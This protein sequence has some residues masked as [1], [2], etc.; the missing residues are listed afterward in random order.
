LSER[1]VAV[2]GI[3]YR[4]IHPFRY[5]DHAIFFARD[6]ETRRLASLVAVYRGVLLYG[7]SGSGKSSL[8]NAGLIPEAIRL[9]FA[10]E[11]LRVQPRASEE[12]VVERI[13]SA[14]DEEELLPSVLALGEESPAR[15]VLAIDAFEERVRAACG[16]HRPLLI[17]D[18]FEEIV[19]LFD[20]VGARD[21]QRRLAE[22]LVRLLRGPLPVKVLLSFREDYLGKVKELLSA[23]PELVDQALRIAPPT[24]DAL[25][26]IIRGPFERYPDHFER[27]LSPALADRLVRVLAE[28]FGAG[29]IS[30]SEV[31]TVCLRLWQSDNPG[32]LLAQKGPQG[33]LED[34]LGEA[35]DAMPAHLRP[36]AVA[37]LGQM[38]TPAGTRNVI[39]AADLF[40]RVQEAERGITPGLLDQAL[41][42]LSQSRLVRRERRRDLNLYEITSE[43]LVPWI[44]RRRDEFRQLQERRRRRR[45]RRRLLIVTSLALALLL[46]A[47]VVT[48]LALLAVHS[49]DQAR[50]EAETA[51]KEAR[52]ATIFAL[53]SAAQTNAEKGPD[54]ALLLSLAAL[55]PNRGG[56]AI[57]AVARSNMIQALETTQ[58]KGVAGI[59][60][61]DTGPVNSVAFS[62][63]GRTLAS[64]SADGSARLWDLATHKQ[65]GPALDADTLPVSSVAFSPDGPTLAVGSDNDTVFLWDLATHTL[66]RSPLR[67]SAYTSVAF[68]LDGRTL[69]TGRDNGRVRLWDL[70]TNRPLGP[71]LPGR[72]SASVDSVAFSPDG[73]MLAAGS[74]DGRVRLW[75][76]ATNRPL[77]PPL[78]GRFSASVDSVAFSPDG[79]MLAAGSGDGRVR[80]WDPAAHRPLGPALT[81]S[82]ASVNSVAFSH[83]GRT[84]A[85]GSGDGTVELWDPATHSPLGPAL[86]ASAAS[87][88]SVAFSPD[89]RTLASGS[90]D[91]TVELWDVATAEQRGSPL[92]VITNSHVSSLALSPD[93]RTLALGTDLGTDLS[94]VQLWDVATH[95][96]LGLP[97]T[98]N[99][100]PVT[101]PVSS[102]ALSP[103]GRTLALGTDL[104]T[105][106]LWDVATHTQLG[107]SLT[108]GPLLLGS[109]AFSHDGRT[110]AAGGGDGTVQL[111]DV[112]THRRLGAALHAGVWV[113]SVALSADGRTLAVGGADGTVRLWDVATHTRL[114]LR[115]TSNTW[116]VDS[117][118]FSPDGRTLASGSGNGTVQL[119]DVATHTQLGL[120]LTSNTGPVNSLAFSPDGRTL[121]SASAATA[122][123]RLWSG[124]LWRDF[125]ELRNQVCRLVG[126][127]LSQ[128]EWA[129]YAP[130]I[131]YQHSCP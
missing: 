85:S 5:L 33:L 129:L 32:A 55:A 26:A 63:D 98:S 90:G 18:Q 28:R 39:S 59:L 109:V 121:A 56:P 112:A 75:D 93:G 14:D 73:R 44:S 11:R 16:R 114:G 70:A 20:K 89:G 46:V 104:G 99:T 101:F 111:W 25:S 106:Q 68:S 77:G 65:L 95:T 86:T 66:L 34:Y 49:S 108:G 72:F 30:L 53:A 115:L 91:G 2:P 81:A 87:V 6:E 110:L 21:A 69:A 107:S 57:P 102:L 23:C 119:W 58:L 122:T 88:N 60:H 40:Q 41:E 24:A 118:A 37:L 130:G 9:G 83:D 10:P 113:D 64:G 123:V 97:L 15:T 80:L 78:P 4:G 84:L 62:P 124:F 61:G 7:D 128:T 94:T 92:T 76:L 38:V 27:Q 31:Q 8:V 127:G 22:L 29:E 50:S 54:A 120:P 3:P 82:A 42:G 36:A 131:A 116:P 74:G 12:L 117:L 52:T 48:S 126:T 1:A 103:D 96:Q 51:S 47:A 105:V 125:A 17:F 71:R 13:G 100:W 79:R 35:L 19:T 45:E 67:A 43:F